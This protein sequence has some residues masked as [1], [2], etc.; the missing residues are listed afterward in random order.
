M[1]LQLVIAA[2]HCT[3]CNE[4]T[5]LAPPLIKVEHHTEAVGIRSRRLTGAVPNGL[6]GSRRAVAY[7]P[8]CSTSRLCSTLHGSIGRCDMMS[9]P[10]VTT[11]QGATSTIVEEGYAY[12]VVVVF[13]PEDESQS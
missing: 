2:I 12:A 10:P 1:S 5:S 8:G 4:C 3:H 11:E 9:S 6:T 7:G 13:I